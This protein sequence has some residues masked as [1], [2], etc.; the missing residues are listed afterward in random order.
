MKEKATSTMTETPKAPPKKPA[1]P[2]WPA[3]NVELWPLKKIKPYERNA[4]THS[5]GQIDQIVA[6]M[7]RFGVTAPV[8]IDE[9]GILIYGHG[10]HA[11]AEKLGLKKLPV[12][13]AHGWTEAEKSAY[14]IMDNQIALNSDWNLPLLK[15]EIKDLMLDDY[16]ISLLGFKNNELEM[17]TALPDEFT[18][19]GILGG[20]DQHGPKEQQEHVCPKCGHKFF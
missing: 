7:K 12:S 11:A 9:K 13:I 2:Q 1:L 8:L 6:S 3:T 19:Q 15:T 20:L 18:P 10:R 17:L 16:D 5:D 14:R 4:R